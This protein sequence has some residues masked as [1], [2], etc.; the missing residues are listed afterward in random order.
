MI[1][2]RE[3]IHDNGI[4]EDN[5]ELSSS[6]SDISEVGKID[7][8]CDFQNLEPYLETRKAKPNYNGSKGG[9]SVFI[10]CRDYRNQLPLLQKLGCTRRTEVWSLIIQCYFP[11]T[12][13]STM[14]KLEHM[15]SCFFQ[16]MKNFSYNLHMSSFCFCCLVFL[17]SNIF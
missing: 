6:S 12:E 5:N 7:V 9:A 2:S 1:I 10:L 16:D 13:K 15:R 17:L 8:G 3:N 4:S 14:W 11:L